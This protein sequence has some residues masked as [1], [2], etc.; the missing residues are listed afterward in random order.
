MS[1]TLDTIPS[2][3]SD[4]GPSLVRNRRMEERRFDDILEL[5]AEECRAIR[6][7]RDNSLSYQRMIQ[8]AWLTSLITELEKARE[9]I[10][11]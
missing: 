2:R 1:I 8:R 9:V 5:A 10:G 3:A 7:F 11:E 4:A 6:R